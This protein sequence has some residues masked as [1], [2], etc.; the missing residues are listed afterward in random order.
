M[1]NLKEF[2]ELIKKYESITLEDINNANISE[3]DSNDSPF[4]RFKAE[5]LT[6]FSSLGCTLCVPIKVN[7]SLCVWE[8]LD[9][10]FPCCD[11]DNEPTY[12]NIYYA[13]DD[14]QLLKAF[15]ERAKYMRK[16]LNDKDIE[17]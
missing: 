6:G 3:Y 12:N 14:E 15:K 4:G 17:I 1:E 2:K 11:G 7:C 13:K 8:G 16:V 9:N 5:E 10:N